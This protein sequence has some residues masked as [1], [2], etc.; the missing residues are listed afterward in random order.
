MSFWEIFALYAA[1]T[2]TIGFVLG[3]FLGLYIRQ[4]R[5]ETQEFIAAQGEKT[6]EEVRK[7]QRSTG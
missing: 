6:R 7:L 4:N 1:G 2:L 5:R 3:I